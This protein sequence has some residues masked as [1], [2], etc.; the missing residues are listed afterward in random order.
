MVFLLVSTDNVID[1][2][3]KKPK[4]LRGKTYVLDNQLIS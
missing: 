4:Y 2:I 1:D 3:L